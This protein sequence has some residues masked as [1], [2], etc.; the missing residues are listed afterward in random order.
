MNSLGREHQDRKYQSKN[1]PLEGA[2]DI[3]GAA[4]LPPSNVEQVSVGFGVVQQLVQNRQESLAIDRFAE[5]AIWSA[6]A[7][8]GTE[9]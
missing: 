7:L 5:H 3:F 1:E 9:V 4:L 8:E 2:V 6:H